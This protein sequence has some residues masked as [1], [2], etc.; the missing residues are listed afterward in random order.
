MLNIVFF[1]LALP[2]MNFIV[3]WYSAIVCQATTSF[4][5]GQQVSGAIYEKACVPV[6]L[7]VRN[8]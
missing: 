8:V 6:F 2:V 3:V 1:K 5:L 7:S 4:V